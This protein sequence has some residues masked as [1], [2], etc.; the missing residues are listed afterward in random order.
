MHI[1][2]HVWVNSGVMHCYISVSANIVRFWV[3][4]V[5][6][7]IDRLVVSA[8]AD[9]LLAGGQR[10]QWNGPLVIS[11]LADRWV[12]SGRCEQWIGSLAISSLADDWTS[13]GPSC[14]RTWFFLYLF[15]CSCQTHLEIQCKGLKCTL[16]IYLPEIVRFIYDRLTV[17]CKR[18]QSI[19]PR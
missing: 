16:P 2:L 11:V 15:T 17:Q 3:A 8:S 9:R 18:C 13:V 14:T 7:W 4:N 1:M 12:L 10:E 5:R 6:P 19:S